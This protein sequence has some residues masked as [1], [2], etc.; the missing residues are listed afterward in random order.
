MSDGFAEMVVTA[1]GFFAELAANNSK[2]WFEP[3]KEQHASQI[4]R[5]AELLSE[6]LAEDLSRL[7]GRSHAGKVY[8]IHRDVRFSKDKSPYNAHLHILW[9]AG[10]GAPGW[11]LAVEPQALRFR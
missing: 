3:R 6:I 11:F 8:R 9:S 7:T 4:R 5:P 10:E 2:D 1:Q